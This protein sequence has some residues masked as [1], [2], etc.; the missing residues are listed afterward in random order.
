MV[1]LWVIFNFLFGLLD[2]FLFSLNTI[3]LLE[4]SAFNNQGYLKKDVYEEDSIATK[5]F[6]GWVHV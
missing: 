6:K 3:L 1:Q 4:P 5:C 2:T